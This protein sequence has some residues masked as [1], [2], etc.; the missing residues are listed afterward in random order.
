MWGSLRPIFYSILRSLSA[1]EKKE[2]SLVKGLTGAQML[3]K[4]LV[5]GQGTKADVW[6]PAWN[7]ER[8]GT[9]L[10]LTHALH[11]PLSYL[12][13]FLRTWQKTSLPLKTQTLQDRRKEIKQFSQNQVDFFKLLAFNRKEVWVRQEGDNILWKSVQDGH[14]QSLWPKCLLCTYK[15]NT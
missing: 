14:L 2:S 13:A 11:L 9:V 5:L 1:L 6:G 10:L 4:Q 7:R 8:L 12:T 15:M 3:I